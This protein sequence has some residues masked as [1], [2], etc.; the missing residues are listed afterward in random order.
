[1]KTG[2]KNVRRDQDVQASR[3]CDDDD[4][5]LVLSLSLSAASMK[6]NRKV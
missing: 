4:L 3:M 2:D 6:Q 5:V 1:M